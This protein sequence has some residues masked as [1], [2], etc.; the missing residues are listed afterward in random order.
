[1]K[2]TFLILAHQ[3]PKILVRL[4]NTLLQAGHTVALHYDLKAA[5]AGYEEVVRNF[6]T[7]PSVRFAK[8]VKV[9]WGE[10][11]IC[12]ATLNCIEEIEAS[13]W[14]PDYVYY[15]SGAD[16]PI[17]SARELSAFLERNKGMEFI[18]GVPSDRKRWV[19][20]GPQEERYQYRFWF[21]WRSQHKRSV[22]LLELQQKLKLRR[23]FVL[24][25][26]P[27][28]GSQWWVLT[29]K[30]LQAVMTVARRPEVLR[31]F[32]TTM[33][34][35]E[36]FFQTLVC[37]LVPSASI[38]ARPLTL[39]QFTD[40]YLPIIFCLDRVEYLVRQPFFLARKISPH[41]MEIFD[42]LD[43]VWM[44][45]GD[46]AA[47]QDEKI[48]T[49]SPEYEMHRLKYRDGVPGVPVYGKLA[50]PWYQDLER[51]ALP[52]FMVMGLSGIELKIAY[53][54][55]SCSSKVICHGQI[56]HPD[57][58][59]FAYDADEFAGYKRDAVALRNVS[60]PNFLGNLIRALPNRQTGFLVRAG[61]GWHVPEIIAN[62]Q[63]P[64]MLILRGDPLVAFAEYLQ[65]PEPGLRERIDWNVINMLPPSVLAKK[66]EEFLPKFKS[67]LAEIE[68]L[69]SIGIEK[70]EG[71]VSR[72]LVE[73]SLD[74]TERSGLYVA[75]PVRSHTDLAGWSGMVLGRWRD[76]T[77]SVGKMF[78]T[79]LP[80]N[81]PAPVAREISTILA[82]LESGRKLLI[83][84]LSAGGVQLPAGYDPED[85]S[86]F[87]G[88]DAV[89]DQEEL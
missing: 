38:V 15:A 2:I 67:S 12:Q 57:L 58:L 88:N 82:G 78:D 64:A 6:G 30:T 62:L 77:V 9:G 65:G 32:K 81:I 11:S 63:D 42:R 52:Y 7:H 49:I 5:K 55:L 76:W 8:R 72:W 86:N 24:G 27:Y 10:W 60:A 80:N 47:L 50:H 68:R 3:H 28:M 31:F 34:P 39:Y 13:G 18:E 73:A 66:W 85:S 84:V 79:K 29:W 20:G 69:I 26:E 35:D 56:F 45:P 25:L 89:L 33:I 16:Y 74:V 23:K 75:K 43:E 71:E 87:L 40:Y 59:E 37:N 4:V 83:G 48:A 54:L 61:Q 22:F 21:N 17:R 53:L 1:M 44:S 46:P 36:L 19:K 51:I 70:K 41:R 14:E